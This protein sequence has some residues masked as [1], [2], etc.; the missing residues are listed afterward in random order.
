MNELQGGQ[1]VPSSAEEGWLREPKFAQTGWCWSSSTIDFLD[2]HH[3]GRSHK[4]LG[5]VS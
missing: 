2:Q 3:P 1:N 5:I 4:V